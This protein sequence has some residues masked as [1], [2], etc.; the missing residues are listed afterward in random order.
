MLSLLLASTSFL[1][2]PQNV[3]KTFRQ[4]HIH[5]HTYQALNAWKEDFGK[6]PDAPNVLR[7]EISFG[8]ESLSHSKKKQM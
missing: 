3:Q 7:Q 8:K 5:L 1:L 4:E 6:E 2:S